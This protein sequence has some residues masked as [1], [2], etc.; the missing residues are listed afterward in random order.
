MEEVLNLYEEPHDPK[1]AVVC[2]EEMA[3]QMVA[4]TRIPLPSPVVLPDRTASTSARARPSLDNLNTHTTASLY[5]AI[6]P[7]EARRIASKLEFHHTPKHG[8]WLNQVEI[9]FSVL[10]RQCLSGL[11][12]DK[13]TMHHG[14]R[15]EPRFVCKM[16]AGGIRLPENVVHED[17][18]MLAFL[19]GYP[20]AYGYTLVAPKEHREQVSGDF[21]MEEY[22]G[23]QRL[24]Y[25]V[26]E[27]V[28]EEVGAERMYIFTFGSNEGN[29]HVHWHGVPLPPGVHYGDQQG[30]WTS[31]SKGVLDIPKEEMTSLATPI[32]RTFEDEA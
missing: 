26:T 2:F 13:E 22:V 30:A 12:P 32:R 5:K 4:E 20:R 6:E 16:V 14:F 31:W 7:G 3:Y 29:S 8:S 25:R 11:I 18:R 28:R 1:H 27:A 23:L 15:T 24:V 10:S 9:E 19:D 17:D 21:T